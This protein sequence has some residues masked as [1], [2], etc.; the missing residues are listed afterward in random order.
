MLDNGAKI[1]I[2]IIV[3]NPITYVAITIGWSVTYEGFVILG[4]VTKTSKRDEGIMDRFNK[5]IGTK[6]YLKDSPTNYG[7]SNK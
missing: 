7:I 1:I 3:T 5:Y 2:V 6:P 4:V